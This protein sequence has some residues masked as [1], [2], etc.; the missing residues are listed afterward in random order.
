MGEGS[1]KIQ[2]SS[3]KINETWD[4]IYGMMTIGNKIILCI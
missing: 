4:V 2:T 3:Y 1:L